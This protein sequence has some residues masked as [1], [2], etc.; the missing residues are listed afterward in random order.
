MHHTIHSPEIRPLVRFAGRRTAALMNRFDTWASDCRLFY[1]TV[2]VRLCIDGKEMQTEENDFLLLPPQ[3]RSP[4][5]A[6]QIVTFA[7]L[8]IR[9]EL[10]ACMIL[11][12]TKI[13]RHLTGVNSR[14][15]IGE[16]IE[17]V[18]TNC[19]E[20]LTDAAIAARFH[21]IDNPA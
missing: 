4:S 6:Y 20:P 21:S 15:G 9:A 3:C 13:F 5:A 2:P 10:S 19:A 18:R 17:Y 7:D 8:P 14:G 1:F 12:L 11:V 16:I